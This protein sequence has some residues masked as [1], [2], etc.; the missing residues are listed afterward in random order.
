MRLIAAVA[1][2]ICVAL[3]LFFLMQALVGGREGFERGPDTGKVVDFVRI[4]P[5]EAVQTRDRS[6]PREPPPPDKPPPPPKLDTAAPREAVRQ[7]LEIE[8]PDIPIGPTG[9]PVVATAWQPGE[10]SVD[11]D[12]TPLVRIEPQYPRDAL[13][14]NIEGWVRLRFTINADGSVAD[15]EVVAAEPPR[16]FNR[17]A[18]R[19]I[20]RWK[21][22]PRIVEG[23][24][25]AR[26]AEQVIEFKID[27]D[28]P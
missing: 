28:R 4:R 24:A 19:A 1:G 11:A 15:P 18:M 9:G 13:M 3:L 2:G 12:V 16:I 17:E 14:R 22:R 26:R 6:L 20:L 5:E 10:T 7:V 27:P 23:Q 8:T 21:F 25:V